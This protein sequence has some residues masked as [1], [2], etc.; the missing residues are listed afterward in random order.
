MQHTV[1][2]PYN[3]DVIV[4]AS[5][6]PHTCT[7]HA[8]GNVQHPCNMCP[9]ATCLPHLHT[10]DTV[11]TGADELLLVVAHRACVYGRVHRCV[12]ETCELI[13]HWPY[14]GCELDLHCVDIDFDGRLTICDTDLG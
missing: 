9:N 10:R 2:H 7:I 6:P 12:H 3:T 11:A 5:I 1:H 8:A 13:A 4:Y 14:A